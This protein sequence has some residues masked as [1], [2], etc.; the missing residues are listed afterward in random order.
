MALVT[1]R[2]DHRLFVVRRPVM[3]V[4]TPV[5]V[6]A[7]LLLT[8]ITAVR[9]TRPIP[10]HTVVGV[11]IGVVVEPVVAPRGAIVVDG[12][13]VALLVPPCLVAPSVSRNQIVAFAALHELQIA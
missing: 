3:V 13:E 8:L 10:A 12:I 1:R 6:V 11:P 7:A 5:V 9:A 2:G 4:V